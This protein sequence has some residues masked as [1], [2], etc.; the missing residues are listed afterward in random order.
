MA[1][2]IWTFPKIEGTIPLKS[3][4]SEAGVDAIPSTSTAGMKRKATSP[5]LKEADIVTDDMNVVTVEVVAKEEK[6]IKMDKE[7][8]MRK[9]LTDSALS[10]AGIGPMSS[11]AFFESAKKDEHGSHKSES[12]KSKKKK[13][14]K[15]KHKH[16]HKHKHDHKHNKEKDK[17]KKK[18]EKEKEKEKEKVKVKKEETLSSG[19]SSPGSNNTIPAITEFIF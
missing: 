2:D 3:A 8:A 17:E 11:S 5:V 15:K 16:K 4:T 13:K 7:D 9:E 12:S 1:A 10:L 18:E 6:K 19:S 14:D